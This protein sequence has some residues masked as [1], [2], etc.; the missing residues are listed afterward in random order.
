MARR[1]QN[2]KTILLAAAALGALAL[3]CGAVIFFVMGDSSPIAKLPE[4][5]V[6]SYMDG[7]NLWSEEDYA[8]RGKVENVLLRSDDRT[9][10]LVSI[11]PHG[12]DFLVPVLLEPVKPRSKPVQREQKLL[13]QVHLGPAGEVRCTAYE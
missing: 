6:Q 4:F 9:K 8:L 7:G 2:P 12:S 13:L 10:Y 3:V 11:R 1:K 5:P